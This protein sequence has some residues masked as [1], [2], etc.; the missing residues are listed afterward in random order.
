MIDRLRI[1]PVK[2]LAAFALLLGYAPVFLLINAHFIPDQRIIWFLL[3]I[4]TLCW[5]CLGY[6]LPQRGR[7][8]FSLIGCGGLIGFGCYMLPAYGFGGAF[9]TLIPCMALLILMLMAWSRPAWDEWHLAMWMVGIILHLVVRIFKKA[10]VSAQLDQEFNL[11]LIIYIFLFL[12]MLNRQGLRTGMHGSRK[13]PAAMRRR[14]QWLL[15]VLFIPAALAS[16]W[17][18]L[19]RG[20]ERFWEWIKSLI[21]AAVAWFF[22]LLESENLAM[23]EGPMGAPEMQMEGL[24]EEAGE[25]GLVSQILEKILIV[26]AALLFLAAVCFALW[27]LWKKLKVLICFI[28]NWLRRF[29]ASAMEDYVDETESTLD[30]DEKKKLLKERIK[31]ALIRPRQIPWETLNGRDRV[32]RLYQ[33]FLQKHPKA[34]GLTARESLN[35]EKKYSS[36]QTEEF[37]VL[38]EKARYSS[39]E[40]SIEEADG[41]RRKIK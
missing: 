25:P 13:A 20:L 23:T 38:Y 6:L 19:G 11:C 32:R 34:H 1:L 4:C 39:H 31:K 35:Q 28:R 10:Y 17:G 24:M 8:I 15:T 30:V 27:F 12:T 16:C 21:G 33:Q 37:T 18:V 40:I 5:G 2:A 36:Q 3:P 26:F 41:L 22:S 9:I 7:L 14:N 29:A